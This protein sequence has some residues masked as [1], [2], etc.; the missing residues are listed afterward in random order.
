MNNMHEDFLCEVNPSKS[1]KNNETCSVYTYDKN[2]LC[3]PSPSTPGSFSS[4]GKDNPCVSRTSTLPVY[5]DECRIFD[6]QAQASDCGSIPDTLADDTL[7]IDSISTTD[8]NELDTSFELC[9]GK[10]DKEWIDEIKALACELLEKW[11]QLPKENYRIP[12]LERQETEKILHISHPV[13]STLIS[14]G[15]EYK[16]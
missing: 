4:S 7:E 16:G 8:N 1:A 3:E 2:S 10:S 9:E 12:R 5:T 6:I 15:S 11:S 13:G 14:W